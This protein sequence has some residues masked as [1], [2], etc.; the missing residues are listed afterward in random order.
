MRNIIRCSFYIPQLLSVAIKIFTCVL[1]IIILLIIIAKEG[2]VKPVQTEA[3]KLSFEETLCFHTAPT[4]MGLKAASLVSLPNEEAGLLETWLASLSPCLQARGLHMLL[5]RRGRRRAL[6][7]IYDAQALHKALQAK[8]AQQLLVR[9]GFPAQ[10]TLPVLLTLLTERMAKGPFPH[11]IGLFLGYPPE[12]V[13]GFIEHKGK[14]CALVGYWKVYGDKERA[15]ALFRRYDACARCLCQKLRAGATM[16][17]VLETTE[18][19]V[20]ARAG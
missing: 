1:K 10:A 13:A 19:M 18:P 17:E 7:L 6:L 9:C 15:A 8:E 3:P 5:L 20:S 2:E 12:D 16:A 14:G 4:L 11:E